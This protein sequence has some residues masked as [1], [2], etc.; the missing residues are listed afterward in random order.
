MRKKTSL[1]F[2]RHVP[3]EPEITKDIVLHSY[4]FTDLTNIHQLSQDFLYLY[5]YDK[6]PNDIKDEPNLEYIKIS[7]PINGLEMNL[8]KDDNSYL[9][10][11]KSKFPRTQLVLNHVL[12]INKTYLVSFSSNVKTFPSDLNFNFSWLEIFSGSIPNI[13]LRYNMGY[14]EIVGVKCA[15]LETVKLPFK[16]EVNRWIE[17]KLE[18]KLSESDGFVRVYRDNRQIGILKG[19]TLGFGDVHNIRFGISSQEMKLKSDKVT[20]LFK[21]F[22]VKQDLY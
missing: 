20:I 11:S 21:D 4:K 7:S 6:H 12:E 16:F 22:N 14:H 8:Y 10:A 19:D 9:E 2:K 3:K 15:P 17:W 13:I 18:F 5:S 1:S